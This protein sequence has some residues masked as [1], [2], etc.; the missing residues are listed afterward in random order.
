MCYDEVAAGGMLPLEA[1]LQLQVSQ[2]VVARHP[3]TRGLHD[4]IILS[5]KGPKYR[6][7]FNRWVQQ[8]AG[9][10]DVCFGGEEADCLEMAEEVAGLRIS[11]VQVT[12]CCK[13]CSSPAPALHTLYRYI[14]IQPCLC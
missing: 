14:V 8:S 11:P 6:V 12:T 2:A 1:P 5:I 7:Q 4:G 9:T 10:S 3:V 13:Q